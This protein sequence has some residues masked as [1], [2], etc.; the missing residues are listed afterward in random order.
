MEIKLK[1]GNITQKEKRFYLYIFYEVKQN[2]SVKG[3]GSITYDITGQS[4]DKIKTDLLLMLQDKVREI[5][6][7]EAAKADLRYEKMVQTLEVSLND[8]IQ[9]P[10]K[11]VSASDTVIADAPLDDKLKLDK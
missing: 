8:F 7:L 9:K 2:L 3:S 11:G 10:Y 6:A 5:Q 1:M 4:I